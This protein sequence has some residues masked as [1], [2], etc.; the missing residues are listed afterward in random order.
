VLTQTFRLFQLCRYIHANP[1]KAG[2]VSTPEEWPFSNFREWIG[3][4][5][6]TFWEQDFVGTNF[7]SAKE[8]ANFVH[9]Y[10]ENRRELPEE[11]KPF[12]LDGS[13]NFT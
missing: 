3:M 4:R 5:S 8:Y 2:L 11:I 6:G 10:I 1:V 12:L 13:M 9:E 7:G